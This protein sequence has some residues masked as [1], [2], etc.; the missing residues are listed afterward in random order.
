MWEV[1]V[2]V[3]QATPEAK[4]P[5]CDTRIKQASTASVGGVRRVIEGEKGTGCYHCRGC[6]LR[7][8]VASSIKCASRSYSTSYEHL[9]YVIN[10]RALHTGAGLR[11]RGRCVIWVTSA[12]H[13]SP[14]DAIKRSQITQHPFFSLGG[15]R[16]K[17]AMR[18]KGVKSGSLTLPRIACAILR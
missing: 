11:S 15:S 8:W 7:V 16:P 9:R 2:G 17:Q 10:T 1:R 13:V 18:P 6:A 14:W 4:G 5:T 12:S 3:R